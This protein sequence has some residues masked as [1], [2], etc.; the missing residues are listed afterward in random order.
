MTNSGFFRSRS[1]GRFKREDAGDLGIG[2]LKRQQQDIINAQ[3][4]NLQTL[5]KARDQTEQGLEGIGR[6]QLFNQQVINDLRNK[7]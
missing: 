4:E 6:S 2:S 5:L 1:K 7:K 3:K